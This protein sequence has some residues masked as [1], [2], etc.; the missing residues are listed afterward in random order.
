MRQNAPPG[1]LAGPGGPQLQQ[2]RP[3]LHGA[4]QQGQGGPILRQVGRNRGAEGAKGLIRASS[5]LQGRPEVVSAAAPRHKRG[6]PS[7]PTSWCGRDRCLAPNSLSASS[8]AKVLEATLK[9]I[10]SMFGK[11]SVMR[12]SDAPDMDV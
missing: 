4:G 5:Q 8:Q 10:N 2:E 11:N 7:P 6:A 9:N 3:P 12:M 1:G